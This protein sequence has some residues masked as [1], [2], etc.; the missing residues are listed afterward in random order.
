MFVETCK[1]CYSFGRSVFLD[2]KSEVFQREVR[3][4]VIYPFKFQQIWKQN[5]S[6]SW[7][8]VAICIQPWDLRRDT[9]WWSI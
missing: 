8:Q 2:E 1:T 5:L 9:N 6:F 4:Q 3:F 7:H